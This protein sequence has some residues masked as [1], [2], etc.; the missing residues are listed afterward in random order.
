[1]RFMLWI[2]G[3]V[4]LLVGLAAGCEGVYVRE[5]PYYYGESP[6]YDYYYGQPEPYFFFD[7]GHRG[8]LH[9]G[10]EERHEGGEPRGGDGGHRR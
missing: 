10:M 3:L 6:Y 4:T 7:G 8:E 5:R 2:I 1:M 9:E